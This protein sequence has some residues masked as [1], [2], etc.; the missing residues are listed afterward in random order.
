M[1][2]RPYFKKAKLQED[3]KFGF[4]CEPKQEVDI[5]GLKPNLVAFS[6]DINLSSDIAVI[7]LALILKDLSCKNE[8]LTDLYMADDQPIILRRT[9]QLLSRLL[10]KTFSYTKDIEV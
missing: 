1:K 9:I 2:D 3:S 7:F 6:E 4:L 10:D 5:E 8:T